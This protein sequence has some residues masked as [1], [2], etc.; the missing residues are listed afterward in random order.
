MIQLKKS[1]L[2]DK[3]S[4]LSLS[5]CNSLFRNVLLG[6]SFLLFAGCHNQ[7][8]SSFTEP[9]EIYDVYKDKVKCV[10]TLNYHPNVVGAKKPLDI[11]QDLSALSRNIFFVFSSTRENNNRPDFYET[12]VSFQSCQETERKLLANKTFGKCIISFEE[13][14]ITEY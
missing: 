8:P 6:L 4:Y 3:R 9:S 13:T 7:S 10:A 5:D 14:S 11:T 1:L 12:F 2:N